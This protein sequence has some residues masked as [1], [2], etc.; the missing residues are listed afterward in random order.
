MQTNQQHYSPVLKNGD[1]VRVKSN[2]DFRANQDGMVVQADDG[3]TVG[4]IFGYD[5]HNQSPS[6]LNITF[7][8]LTEEWSLDELDLNTLLH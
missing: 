1:F 4:F 3:C 5:R 8:G 6:E 2:S 7:T